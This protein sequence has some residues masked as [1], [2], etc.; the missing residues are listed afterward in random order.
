MPTSI[1]WVST[2]TI[3]T[4][5]RQNRVV[6]P[7]LITVS[8]SVDVIAAGWVQNKFRPG[9]TDMIEQA[10]LDRIMIRSGAPGR[11]TRTLEYL[12]RGSGGMTIEYSS[13]KGGTVQTTVQL[14]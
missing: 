2:P 5:A 12:V 7:D 13:L 3:T 11:H 4:K 9:P 10:E 14:R 6:R 8:G 1:G